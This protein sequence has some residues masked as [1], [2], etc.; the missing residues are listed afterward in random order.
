METAEVSGKQEEQEGH[1][2]E[3]DARLTPGKIIFPPEARHVAR[4]EELRP[5][6]PR[7][8]RY[9]DHAELD[10]IGAPDG[11]VQPGDD[12]DRFIPDYDG[13]LPVVYLSGDTSEIHRWGVDYDEN[14]FLRQLA[15]LRAYIARGDKFHTIVGVRRTNFHRLVTIFNLVCELQGRPPLEKPELD[16]GEPA[17][18]RARF[19]EHLTDLNSRSM[20]LGFEFRVDDERLDELLGIIEDAPSRPDYRREELLRAL[21]PVCKEVFTGPRFLLLDPVGHCNCDCVYCRLFS[22]WVKFPE[23]SKPFVYGMMSLE[24][25]ETIIREAKELEVEKILLVGRGEP[26]M[27]PRFR[28]V[29][30]LIKELGMLYSVSTNGSLLHTFSDLVTDGSCETITVSLSYATEES[31]GKIRPGTSLRNVARIDRNVREV[32]D[33]K[34][35]AG[36]EHP[37]LIAL[38]AICKYNFREIPQMVRHAKELGAD[39]IWY[40]LVHL[41]DFCRDEL[42]MSPEEMDEV[43]Q[44]LR[45]S[46]QVAEELGL[47]WNSFIDYEIEHYNEE[48]GDWSHKGLLYEGCYVGWHFAFI[49]LFR[50]IQLC[51]GGVTVGFL[52]EDGGG[53]AESWRS[54]LFRR[55]RNDGLIMHRENPL[56]LYGVPL[57]RPYC[58]SCDNHDQNT[59]MMG[60]VA[61]YGLQSF[62]ER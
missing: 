11:E 59:M 35:Q 21:G 3:R 56:D 40:Q 20:P 9:E 37:L 16:L 47:Q 1:Q 51:C 4:L 32:A 41:E 22:P 30:S 55:Y 10:V 54:H 24:V 25:M 15:V 58:D 39:A 19:Q 53:L 36:V 42:A 62:V 14:D 38:Y 46:R 45:A 5:Q 33:L 49:N 2:D 13:E 57:Y 28:D 60:E 6:Y 17:G 7:L 48:R 43:R 61:K 27:H 52:R 23:T 34:R 18:I 50:E 8:I 31:F 29:V 12:G 44:M 26:T